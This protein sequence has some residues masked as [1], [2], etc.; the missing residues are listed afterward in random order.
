MD[1]SIISRTGAYAIALQDRKLLVVKQT[2]GPHAGKFDL[3]GGRIEPGE[4]A[5]EA[6]RR[7]FLEE[8]ALTFESMQWIQNLTATTG[9]LQQIGMI[10]RVSRFT[11]TGHTAE[12]E[13]AW[14]DLDQLADLP[15]APFL[16]QI[17]ISPSFQEII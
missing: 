13:H 4:M 3:P 17:L 5:E 16:K 10:Y 11:P 6:L 1:P 12:M 7:E 2:K 8:V 14:I 15:L 9:N